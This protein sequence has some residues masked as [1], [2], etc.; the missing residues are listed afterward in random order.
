[1]NLN[2]FF[3][4]RHSLPAASVLDT[5]LAGES[6]RLRD[7]DPRTE[8]KW[9]ELRMALERA[10]VHASRKHAAAALRVKPGLAFGLTVLALAVVGAFLLR[11]AARDMSYSTGRGELSTVFLPDSS[12]VT[13]NH[14]SELVVDR[15]PGERIRHVSL[16]GEAFFRVR[17]GTE[18]FVVTTD[19]GT[20]RVLGTQFNVRDRDRRI[21][22]AVLSGS[23]SVTCGP[24]G[25]SNIVLQTGTMV[26]CTEAGALSAPEKILFTDYPG[27]IHRK[28]LFQ[29]SS[30]SSVC[31]EIEAQF[32]VRVQIENPALL[33][34]T[35][36]GEL[37]SIN[38]E[39]AVAALAALTG[40]TYTHDANV[41]SLH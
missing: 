3:R 15:H 25:A 21:E 28:L 31:G 38:A 17:R 27:W 4:R 22:V 33:H 2:A 30:L 34:E 10:D 39:S 36:T 40:S 32:D 29:R 19:A 7:A 12:E 6:E 20:V 23:V 24:E 26:T 5:A 16:K 37:D 11:P 35:I 13:L 18:P 9:Q 14:T 41:F 8:L 1:M